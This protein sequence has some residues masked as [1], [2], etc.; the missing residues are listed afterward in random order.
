[1]LRIGM[2]SEEGRYAPAGGQ[3]QTLT[4]LLTGPAF[5]CGWAQTWCPGYFVGIQGFF[6]GEMKRWVWVES[7]AAANFC[8]KTN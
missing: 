3:E 5:C 6:D 8:S 4:A 2:K 1:M 7:T